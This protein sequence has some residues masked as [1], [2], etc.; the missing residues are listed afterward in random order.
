MICL[1]NEQC[2]HILK[3]FRNECYGPQSHLNTWK[4]RNYCSMHIHRAEL[5]N[6]KDQVKKKFPNHTITFDVI[7]ESGT[8]EIPWHC[9]YESLGPFHVNN[10]LKSIV[11]GDF[12]SIHFNLTEDGGRLQTYPNVLF[13]YVH[14]IV[15]VL[16]GIY[17]RIHRIFIFM[18]IPFFKIFSTTHSNMIGYGN[19]FN[20]MGLHRVTSG[21][22]RISY[23]VR[24]V[25]NDIKISNKSVKDGIQRS[26]ACKGFKK[27]FLIV[28][29]ERVPVSTIDWEAFSSGQE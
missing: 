24:L 18:S 19:I 27:L 15:I 13:S 6:I 9:D 21:K 29:Q 10:S 16:F 25:H 20:N 2:L 17:S 28:P 23:V 7:F 4:R 5:K 14:Y 1:N 11:N 8:N 26:N 3:N 22:P 12:K